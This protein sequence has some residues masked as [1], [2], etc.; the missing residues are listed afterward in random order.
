M[1]QPQPGP[2]LGQKPLPDRLA[3]LMEDVR[4]MKDSEF[5][6]NKGQIVE[7]I[8]AM[9]LPPEPAPSAV[10]PIPAAEVERVKVKLR[11][12]SGP[13]FQKKNA[14]QDM[15]G[16]DDLF[17]Q[18]RTALYAGD[19]VKANKL[20]DEALVKLGLMKDTSLTAPTVAPPQ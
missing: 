10:K 12:A 13:Y 7:A 4:K 19:T 2:A 9:F 15:D 16:I 18:A 14:G 17:R 8:F 11:L 20:V 5:E 6:Q 3:G 1:P